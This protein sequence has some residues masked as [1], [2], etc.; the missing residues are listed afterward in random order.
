[1]GIAATLQRHLDQHHAC[2]D[3]RSHRPTT[4]SLHTAH[5]AHVPGNCLA[6]SVLLEDDRGFMMAVL[7][8]S[9]AVDLQA[10]A[11]LTGRHLRLA[12]E[13]AFQPVFG[14]CALGAV[15]PLGPIY[16]VETLLDERLADQKEIWF[17]AGDHRELIHMASAE[18]LA[19]L[20]GVMRADFSRPLDAFT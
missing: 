20:P 4:S 6:K 14:D 12:R 16:G 8:A 1:M 3:V 15:P 7:P 11:A 18:F 2:Y 5:S 17:E 19:L 13:S 10:L 9:R